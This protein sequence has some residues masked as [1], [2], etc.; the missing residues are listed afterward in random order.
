MLFPA[1]ERVANRARFSPCA[2][3]PIGEPEDY[4]GSSLFGYWEFC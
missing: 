3:R 4:H 1:L 2:D